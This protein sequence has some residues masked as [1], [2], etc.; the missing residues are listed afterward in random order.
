MINYLLISAFACLFVTPS[1][2]QGQE[3]CKKLNV[4]VTTEKAGPSANAGRITVK[5]D[6]SVPDKDLALHLFG[7]LENR[8]VRDLKTKE[9]TDL[10]PGKYLLVIVDDKNRYCPKQVDIEITP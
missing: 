5:Y 9:I 3:P 8:N 1:L 4:N 7:K 2:A 10:K 6:D